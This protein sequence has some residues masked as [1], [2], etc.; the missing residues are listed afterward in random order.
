MVDIELNPGKGVV[1]IGG[2]T[3]TATTVR[4]TIKIIEAMCSGQQIDIETNFRH[5]AFFVGNILKERNEKVSFYRL[6]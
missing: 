2:K 4:D 6:K 5:E 1:V 3:Y